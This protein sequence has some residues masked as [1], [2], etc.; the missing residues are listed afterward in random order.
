MGVS[1]PVE[2]TGRFLKLARDGLR[3]QGAASAHVWV[4]E[5]GRVHGDHTHIVIHIP[6][7]LRKWWVARQRRWFK[8]CGAVPVKGGIK[9]RPVGRSYHCAQGD[10]Q[11][12]AHYMTNLYETLDY[13]LKGVCPRART[14]FNVRRKAYGGELIGKRTATSQNIGKTAWQ[15]Y[16]DTAGHTAPTWPIHV[17]RQRKIG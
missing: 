15:Q 6:A 8:Q 12:R 13:M 10:E 2:A 11:S 9:S 3:S 14:T 5:C 1:D 16:L 17:R 7:H 4:N